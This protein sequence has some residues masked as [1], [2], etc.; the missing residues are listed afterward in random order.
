M[1]TLKKFVV[2]PYLTYVKDIEPL[3]RQR[4]L[5][6]TAKVNDP[7]KLELQDPEDAKPACGGGPYVEALASHESEPKV[8]KKSG[9]SKKD[10][11]PQKERVKDDAAKEDKNNNPK[12][13]NSNAKNGN[14][15]SNTKSLTEEIPDPSSSNTTKHKPKDTTKHKSAIKPRAQ[16]DIGDVMPRTDTKT[17]RE[18]KINHSTEDKSDSEHS[19]SVAELMDSSESDQED[20]QAVANKHSTNTKEPSSIRKS[21]RARRTPYWLT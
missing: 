21:A 14:S 7:F 6:A 8:A 15:R 16:H 20:S 13:E 3:R 17:I 12:A 4:M 11:V 10:S 18:D 1:G 5:H 19:K 9:A 2:I